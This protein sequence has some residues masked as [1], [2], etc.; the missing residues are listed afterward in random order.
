MP[1]F[2]CSKIK[3]IIKKLNVNALS[4]ELGSA[5]YGDHW[6]KLHYIHPTCLIRKFTEWLFPRKKDCSDAVS[7]TG[8]MQP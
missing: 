5:G 4:E 1:V 7:H 3:S 8:D 6:Q 2:K